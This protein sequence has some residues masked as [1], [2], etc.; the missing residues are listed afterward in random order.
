MNAMNDTIATPGTALAFR[1]GDILTAPTDVMVSTANAGFQ[2]TGGIGA[3]LLRSGGAAFQAE[4][5]RLARAKFGSRPA[6]RG[7]ILVSSG[8]GLHFRAIIHVVAID[9]FYHTTVDVLVACTQD[10]L[11]CAESMGAASV[12]VPAF[13]TGYGRHPLRSCGGAMRDGYLR[14][15]GFLVKLRSV[16]MWL[17]DQRRLDEL[18][19]GWTG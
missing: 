12:A 17:R 11:L 9:V 8:A 15:Q 5:N 10:A 6:P 1:S 13:A 3:L 16:E 18:Q 4:L 14:A 19:G 2:L 7:S